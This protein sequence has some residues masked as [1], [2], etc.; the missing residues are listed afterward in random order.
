MHK[1]RSVCG[2]LVITI[3]AHRIAALAGDAV[4]QQ[5]DRVGCGAVRQFCHGPDAPGLPE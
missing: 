2:L 1:R 4:Y 3:T 5:T